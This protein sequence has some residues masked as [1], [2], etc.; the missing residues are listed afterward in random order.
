[1]TDYLTLKSELLCYGM[2]VHPNTRDILLKEYPHFAEKGF[3]DAV[4]AK[5]GN[6]TLCISIAEAYS[7]KS[8]YILIKK[9]G[10]YYVTKD[11][12]LFKIDFFE[13]LPKTGTIVDDIARLH[14]DGCVNIWPSTSCCYDVD[15]LKCGF[16]SLE[17]KNKKPIE[18]KILCDGLKKLYEKIPAWTLNF[19]GGTY[20]NPDIM[21]DYWCEIARLVREFSNCSIAIEFAPP[22]DLKKLEKLKECGVNVAIM[23]LEIAN[24]VLRRQI[25]PGKSR[26]SYEHYYAALERAVEIFGWGQVSSVLIGGIQP[27]EDIVAECEK[28]CSIGVFP[29]IMPFRPMDNCRLK[30]VPA[31]NPEDLRT[32]SLKLGTMLVKNNLHPHLQEGCTKCGGCSVENDCYLIKR[33]SL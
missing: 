10:A 22:S 32:M 2:E 11:D 14:A 5:I 12:E 28:L 1:M 17:C 8:P 3:I 4:N 21:V 24:P 19:S 9:D 13:E 7:E 25:C 27:M 6:M 23:N 33:N 20:L 15:D 26:I 16:C 29:T 30:D 31:C 18:P